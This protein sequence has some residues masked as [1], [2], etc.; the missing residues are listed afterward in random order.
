LLVTLISSEHGSRVG[1]LPL[2]RVVSTHY[3]SL[4]AIT[5]FRRS[6]IRVTADVPISDYTP[7]QDSAVNSWSNYFSVTAIIFAHKMILSENFCKALATIR[8]NCR[9]KFLCTAAN[10]LNF[11]SKATDRTTLSSKLLLNRLGSTTS[12][13][14]LQ[15]AAGRCSCCVWK[16]AALQ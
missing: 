2:R 4:V 15:A 9:G 1:Q 16:L 3:R 11:V 12:V 10:L 13:M 14:L 7:R 6:P 8:C 5:R